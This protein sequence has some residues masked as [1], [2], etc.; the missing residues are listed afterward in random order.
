MLKALR[1]LRA[2]CVGIAR[3]AALQA[4]GSEA[5]AKLVGP[6]RSGRHG[7]Q[8]RVKPC[9]KASWLSTIRG[10]LSATD[11]LLDI[12]SLQLRPEKFFC[13]LELLVN[14]PSGRLLLLFGPP[15]IDCSL[16]FLCQHGSCPAEENREIL[17]PENHHSALTSL[18]RSAPE[19]SSMPGTK[20][21]LP[22]FAT[23]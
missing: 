10:T 19:V 4:G 9:K 22:T 13:P 18:S 21:C 23:S 15:L 8:L 7:T 14:G 5:F 17:R 3:C 16:G 6:A 2:Q 1:A 11:L 20:A 12:F